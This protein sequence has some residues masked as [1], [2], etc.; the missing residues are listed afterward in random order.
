[1]A[2]LTDQVIRDAVRETL[3]GESESPRRYDVD[4]I[5]S[6]SYAAFHRQAREARVPDC[7]HPDGLKRQSTFIFG[8]LLAMPFVLVA[9]LRGKCN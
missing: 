2:K 8:G 5:T 9:K 4:A 3:A 6:I 1:M 7:L